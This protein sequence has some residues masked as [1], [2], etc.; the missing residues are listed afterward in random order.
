MQEVSIKL[1]GAALR[2]VLK[3]RAELEREY[4]RLYSITAVVEEIIDDY[5]N[6]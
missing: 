2:N 6:S 3:T 5:M 1:Y 4:G